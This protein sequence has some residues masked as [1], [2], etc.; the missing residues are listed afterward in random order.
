MFLH[1]GHFKQK[2]HE[3]VHA[4]GAHQTHVAHPRH[5]AQVDG[6]D[7]TLGKSRRQSVTFQ[8]SNLRESVFNK[9]GVI[10]EGALAKLNTGV[11][12]SWQKRYFEI[13]GK[14]LKY[15]SDSRKTEVK[16]VC[17]L[18]NCE[19]A[20]MINQLDL[21]IVLGAPTNSEI[22]LRLPED[23]SEQD[24]W[25]DAFNSVLEQKGIAI[26]VQEAHQSA[27]HIVSA[28]CYGFMFEMV[29]KSD[30][31][32]PA[33]WIASNTKNP[34]IINV[35]VC[36][37]QMYENINRPDD[38]MQVG[39]ENY[40]QC[41][42]VR[43]VE[44]ITPVMLEVG[45]TLSIYIHTPDSIYGVGYSQEPFTE[46][47]ENIELRSGFPTTVAQP[48]GKPGA[49]S[50]SFVGRL[51]Y[52]VHQ[53][54]K[55][56]FMGR[57]SGMRCYGDMM[58]EEKANTEWLEAKTDAGKKYYYN[59]RTGETS[60]NNPDIAMS[61]KRLMDS[62]VGP[63]GE[64]LSY[65]DQVHRCFATVDSDE[66]G[67]IDQN[68][69]GDLLESIGM[70]FEDGAEIMHIFA[71]IDQNEDGK[72]RAQEFYQWLVE[73][74]GFAADHAV[75]NWS[76]KNKKTGWVQAVDQQGV[77]FYYEPESGDTSWDN[78]DADEERRSIIEERPGITLDERLR[79]I[80]VM[81][82][83][84]SDGQ[85]SNEE[86]QTL[87]ITLEPGLSDKKIAGHVRDIGLDI[88]KYSPALSDSV[89]ITYPS[90]VGYWKRQL[91]SIT[92]VNKGPKISV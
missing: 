11:R 80:F 75:I 23:K 30:L 3:L 81:F 6:P 27:G 13:S 83:T 92:K 4:A 47:D 15:Y 85:L 49:F 12:R 39:A 71:Q 91:Q 8:S 14:Y 2:H 77:K 76:S 67:I 62:F 78:P 59:G 63:D 1:T 32:I 66:D 68:Q 88:Q 41:K 34:V 65:Q 38:W 22:I 46:V 35:Y 18:L 52:V 79:N 28:S 25:T 69:F 24:D 37:G 61:L 21:K 86:F 58:A 48:F 31:K 44:F 19:S 55:T 45:N 87:V 54:K 36:Y 57:T 73:E 89:A 10:K 51:E 20:A 50:G 33:L 17:D 16:G 43:R 9:T 74:T 40:S 64:A 26:S 82:D 56:R 29:A 53:E 84:D 70:K 42:E 90:F 5:L 7:T 60:W 72:V